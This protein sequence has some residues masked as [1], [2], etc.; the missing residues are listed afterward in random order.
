MHVALRPVDVDDLDAFAHLDA[1]YAATYALEPVVTRASLAFYARSGHSFAA[2]PVAA[3]VGFVLAHA[4]WNGAHPTVTVARVVAQDDDALV[5]RALVEAVVKSA[6]DAA[7]YDLAIDLPAADGAA[8]EALD[9]PWRERPV[10]RFER[11]L[12]AR[13]ASAAAPPDDA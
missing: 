5:L 4:V 13:A 12:G 2:G 1:A 10:R 7:V 3:P 8:R 11:V 6:F 9:A